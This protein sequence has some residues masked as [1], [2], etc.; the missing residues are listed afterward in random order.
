MPYFLTSS[1]HD[2]SAH[3]ECRSP[4]AVSCCHVA[5][6]CYGLCCALGN[7]T[8]AQGHRSE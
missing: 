8:Y 2:S 6:L 1:L 4:S 7:L 5:A 3:S